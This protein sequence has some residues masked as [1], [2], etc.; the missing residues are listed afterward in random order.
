MEKE[1]IESLQNLKKLNEDKE[2]IKALEESINEKSKEIEEAKNRILLETDSSLKDIEEDKVEK[3]SE[4]YEN[5]V[6][7]KNSKKE[8]LEIKFNNSK[9][10]LLN[11]I[12]NE[13]KKYKRKDELD[14]LKDSYNAYINVAKNAQTTIERLVNDFNEGKNVDQSMLISA[15]KEKA[16]N[17]ENA[18]KVQEEINNYKE[19]DS[20]IEQYQDLKYL[21]MRI[22]GMFLDN[23][24]EKTEEEFCNKYIKKDNEKVEESTDNKDNSKK[25]EESTESKESDNRKVVEELFSLMESRLLEYRK[26]IQSLQLAV[27]FKESKD[28]KWEKIHTDRMLQ[29]GRNVKAIENEIEEKAKEAKKYLTKEDKIKVLEFEKQENECV[30]KARKY[31]LKYKEIEKKQNEPEKNENNVATNKGLDSKTSKADNLKRKIEELDEDIANETNPDKINAYKL[32]KQTAEK[33]LKEET[34]KKLNNKTVNTIEEPNITKIGIVAYNVDTKNRPFMQYEIDND[35]KY[36]D[37]NINYYESK[38]K[39]E[40]IKGYL[41]EIYPEIDLESNEGMQELKKYENADVNI[42]KVLKSNKK[43]LNDYISRLNG[44]DIEN[45]DYVKIS[46]D[47]SKL[48]KSNISKEEKKQIEENAFKHRKIA[49]IHKNLFQSIKFAIMGFKER[50]ENKVKLLNPAKIEKSPIKEEKEEGISEEAKKSILQLM[51]DKKERQNNIKNMDTYLNTL[52]FKNIYKEKFENGKTPEEIAQE[53]L[54]REES[55]KRA[56]EKSKEIE[57]EFLKKYDGDYEK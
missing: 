6:I 17:E 55:I 57:D 40:L 19:L 24:D 43:L 31:V 37:N 33:E 29:Y 13:L 32:M 48:S 23:L 4:E 18:K 8:E 46:Y 52:E 47:I 7:E 42:V 1:I 53:N 16:E 34:E 15:R 36:D 50:R 12:D 51:K 38:T 9:T 21:Q 5:M 10:D 30:E 54:K 22:N 11:N 3:L 28:E 49:T 35:K 20:N 56:T 44:I 26:S 41:K 25:I 45:N 27:S 14:K 2:N 39:N